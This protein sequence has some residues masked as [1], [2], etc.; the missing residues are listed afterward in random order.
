VILKNDKYKK[1]TKFYLNL[2]KFNSIASQSIN[3][4]K[5]AAWVF[6]AAFAN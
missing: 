3:Y 5:E 4:K 1:A 6:L 2:Y